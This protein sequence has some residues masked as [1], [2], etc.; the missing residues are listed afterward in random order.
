MYAC[1][2]KYVYT[3]IRMLETMLHMT[4]LRAFDVRGKRLVG[5]HMVCLR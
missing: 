3:Y 1:T 4:G 5:Q 2:Y